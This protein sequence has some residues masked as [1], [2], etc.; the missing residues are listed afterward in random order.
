VVLLVEAGALA[1]GA[2]LLVAD[3]LRGGVE[4]VGTTLAVAGFL[5]GLGCLLAA[6]GRALARGRR[7]GRGPA[8]TWQLLQGAIG[9]TQVPTSPAVGA[10]LVA[11][12]ALVVAGLLAPSSLAATSASGTDPRG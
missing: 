8:L 2:V 4:Q 7:W 11:T 12:A 3:V 9:V 6:A 1:A 10:A 5:A